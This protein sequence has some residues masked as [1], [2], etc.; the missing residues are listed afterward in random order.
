MEPA[1]RLQIGTLL[2]CPH[3]RAWHSVKAK[4]SEGTEYTLRMLYWDCRDASYYAGQIGGT[5]RFPTKRIGNET[6]SIK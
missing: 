6:T 2:R 1:I 5:A 4:H 3:C